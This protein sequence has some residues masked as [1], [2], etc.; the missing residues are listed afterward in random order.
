MCL[1]IFLGRVSSFFI[2]HNNLKNTA[3]EYRDY[4]YKST[5]YYCY[6]QG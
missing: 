2:T 1:Y 6:K 5:R 3:L 4:E